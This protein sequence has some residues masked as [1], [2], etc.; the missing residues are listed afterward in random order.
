MMHGEKL[1]TKGGNPA[2]PSME[3]YLQWIVNAWQSLSKDLIIKSFKNCALTI[4]LDGSEDDQIHCFKPGGPI[5]QGL[6]LLRQAR[7]DEHYDDMARMLQEIDMAEDE[8]NGYDSDSSVV[9][10]YI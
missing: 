4:A 7:I 6:E 1:M 8:N 2:P 9:F 3:I 10:E 5:P